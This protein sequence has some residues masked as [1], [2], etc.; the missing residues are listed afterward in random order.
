MRRLSRLARTTVA[1]A[2]CPFEERISD[3]RED[4]DNQGRQGAGGSQ[5]L[6]GCW[7]FQ[8]RLG[9][10]P[11]PS[12]SGAPAGGDHGG[13]LSRRFPSAAS[14]TAGAAASGGPSQSL[15]V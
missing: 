3:V 10:E 5:A 14:L 6:A 12:L 15:Q 13:A 4:G 1:R 11:R 9:T 8:I 7:C 2:A